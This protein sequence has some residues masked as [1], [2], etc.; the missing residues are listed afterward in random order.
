MRYTYEYTLP[1]R[2]TEDPWSRS[3]YSHETAEAACRAM[4]DFAE[5]CYHGGVIAHVRLCPIPD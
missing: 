5:G 1:H 3:P 4:A 2:D